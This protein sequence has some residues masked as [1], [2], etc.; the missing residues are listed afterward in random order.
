MELEIAVLSRTGG[1]AQNED[2]CG[3]WSGQGVCFCV[4]SD[5]AGGH[6]GGD[7]ASKVVV[8]EILGWF[9]ERQECSGAAV[10]AAMRAANNALVAEQRAT[11]RYSDMRA[12][13]VVL[14]IDFER[15]V[16]AWGHLGDS[17]LYCFRSRGIAA[18]TRDHSVV[19]SMVDA[20]YLRPEDM[21]SSP[22]RSKLIG[23][24]GDEQAFSPSVEQQP[25]S[26]QA[27][28]KF[29]LCTDGLWEYLE[30]EEIGRALEQCNSA[31]DWLRSL[32]AHVLSRAANTRH[33]NYS[34]VAVWCKDPASLEG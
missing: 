14:A 18:Q 24:M 25:F 11:P 1:R 19:Q 5:G 3:C 28:D 15:D 27:G 8:R 23:A 30:D 16:A 2:A 10:E 17:R 7:V 32:E 13:V 12:T 29:L 9:R 6:R 34:A 4:L 21:R 33:D 26:V 22:D 31:E 20:G